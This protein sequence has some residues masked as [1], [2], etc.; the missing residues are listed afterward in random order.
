MKKYKKGFQILVK[1]IKTIT[2]LFL[3]LLL[4][5]VLIQKFGNNKY[6]VGGYRIFMIASESMTPEYEIGD[7]LVSKVVEPNTIEVGDNITY[8]G[9][10]GDFKNLVVTHKVISKREE[11]NQYY[12][13]TKGLANSIADPEINEEQVY[14]KV[15]YKATVFSLLGHLLQNNIAYYV[16]FVLV[17]IS[18]S[19]EIICYVKE[20][21][22][23]D[24]EEKEKDH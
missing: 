19:Y 18:L 8:L 4:S 3:L 21:K 22:D 13:Q 5:V 17:G 16:L 11:N 6:S 20:L 1:I 12:F 10:K 24:E 9:A 14:G 7:I 15:V 2:L 23:D